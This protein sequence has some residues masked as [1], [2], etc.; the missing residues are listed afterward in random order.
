MD[1]IDNRSNDAVTSKCYDAPVRVSTRTG[2]M[3]TT[4]TQQ[5]SSSLT[6]HTGLAIS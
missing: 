6:V 3:I 5:H 4:H 1:L 2:H